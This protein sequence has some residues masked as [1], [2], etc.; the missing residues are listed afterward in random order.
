MSVG[1]RH[2]LCLVII[3]SHSMNGCIAYGI[4]YRVD[5]ERGFLKPLLSICV[6]KIG[7]CMTH[8]VYRQFYV[9]P[10][11]A[12]EMMGML[13]LL[14]LWVLFWVIIKDE[15]R[16]PRFSHHLQYVLLMCDSCL[17]AIKTV[18]KK[19][20]VFWPLLICSRQA[21]DFRLPQ[22]PTRSFAAAF[23][24]MLCEKQRSFH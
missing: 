4:V 24:H 7:W 1:F 16:L 14:Q 18:E 6:L 17:Q 12:V 3:W 11:A 8:A 10:E 20:C 5:P 15:E 22:Q 19:Y 21:T 23:W 2:E 9:Y 13:W